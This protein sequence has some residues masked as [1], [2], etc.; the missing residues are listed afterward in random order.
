MGDNELTQ[1]QEQ[2]EKI[3]TLR[4]RQK[5]THIVL[6]VIILITV[7]TYA[8]LIKG[9]IKNFDTDPLFSKVMSRTDEVT[10]IIMKSLLDL[11]QEIMPTYE[12]E[13]THK[14]KEAMPMLKEQTFQEINKLGENIKANMKKDLR[15]AIKA[16]LDQQKDKLVKAFP[17]LEDEETLKKVMNNLQLALIQAGDDVLATSLKNHKDQLIILDYT[18]REFE[19]QELDMSDIE[20]RNALMD[21]MLDLIVCKMNEMDWQKLIDSLKT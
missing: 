1:V 14:L 16:G 3:E 15:T 4:A 18:L 7:V 21:K 20:L 11:G 19:I 17:D 10:P 5:E 2:L 9:V 6:L 13:I 8:M 12:E